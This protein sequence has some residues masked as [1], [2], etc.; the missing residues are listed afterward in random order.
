MNSSLIRFFITIS[1]T[2]PHGLML[3]MKRFRSNLAKASIKLSFETYFGFTVFCTIFSSITAFIVSHLFFSFIVELQLSNPFVLPILIGALSGVLTF[4][5]C[6]AYPIIVYISRS[7]KIDANLPFIAN[8]MSVL[9]T[10]GM[11]PENIIKSLARVA[12]EFNVDRE[13]RGLVAEIELMGSDLNEALRNTSERSPSKRFA[14]LLNGVI[15]TSHMGGDMAAYLRDQAIKYK[16]ERVLSTKIFIDNLSIVAEIYVT[17]MVA[18]PIMLIV[19]LSV[20]SF[21]GAGITVGNIDAKFLMNLLSFVIIP[22]GIILM[23]IVVDAMAPP[24]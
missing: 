11:P 13:M 21:L 20:M 10:S 3:R 2:F 18:A 9:A 15:A 17:F 12:K 24:R 23:I 16:N 7:R 4:V 6:Y 5:L 1:R 14:S 22:L 19:M 8:F